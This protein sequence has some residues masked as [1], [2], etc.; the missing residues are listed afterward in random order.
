MRE[1]CWACL[2]GA[3]MLREE[4][5]ALA[6]VRWPSLCTQHDMGCLL[7]HGH[8]H[9]LPRACNQAILSPLPPRPQ[10][11]AA[12][13]REIASLAVTSAAAAK[14]VSLVLGAATALSLGV[15]L[16]AALRSRS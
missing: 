3:Y 1:V 8:S 9:F 12:A 13:D 4:D 10:A 2:Y 15:A 7:G 6:A 16:V 14:R 11:E 5:A